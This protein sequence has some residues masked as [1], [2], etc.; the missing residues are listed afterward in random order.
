MNAAELNHRL[1]KS[2]LDKVE[3][4]RFPSAEMQDRVE[5]YIQTRE[6]A[7]DYA[8][9]LIAKIEDTRFPSRELVQRA[10]AAVN[11]L[12]AAERS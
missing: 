1:V 10:E 5:Q 12:A 2:L 7:A 11:R 8:E 6:E 4:T 3:E 9:A